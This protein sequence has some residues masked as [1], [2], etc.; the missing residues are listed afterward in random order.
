MS[1]GVSAPV[2]PLHGLV[3]THQVIYLT[4]A[5]LVCL[6]VASNEHSG[7]FFRRWARQEYRTGVV[8][9]LF[10]SGPEGDQVNEGEKRERGKR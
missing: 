5:V 10:S 4:A 3:L 2:V 9:S 1:S 6:C 7:V 8:L